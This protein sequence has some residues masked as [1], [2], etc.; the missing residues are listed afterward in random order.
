MPYLLTG[1]RYY[2]EEMAFWANYACCGPIN[3]DGVRSSQGILAI[4]EV[5]GFGWALRNI[6]DAAAYYPDASP[7]KAY[8]SQKVTN[9]LS[10]LDAYANSQDPITNP[11]PV[12]W[13]DK[14][15]EGPQYRALLGAELPGATRSIAPS[16]RG[17]RAAW[18]IA[19][20]SRSSSCGCSRA[21]RIIRAST[22]RPTSSPSA[23]R[24]SD[25]YAGVVPSD[26]ER[27]LERHAGPERPFAGFYGP[28][29]RLNLMIGIE[30]GW[31]GAQDAY[32]YLWPFVSSELAL[33]AGWAIGAPP[34]VGGGH[35]SDA[36]S[37][38]TIV[39][40]TT[41]AE[42]GITSTLPE[43]IPDFSGDLT[44]VT[45][46]S[47][48]SGNWSS[49][50]TWQGGQVPT[51]NQVVR[52]AQGHTVTIINTAAVAY[53][54][55]VDGKL[56]FCADVNTRLT[57]TNLEVMAGSDGMGTPGVLEVGTAASPIAA[58]VTAEIVIANSPLGGSVADP[59]QFGT[60]MIVFG[61]VVD[62]RQ[63][64]DADLRA[65]SRP[66]RSPARRR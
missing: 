50:S 25:R 5:H 29:A 61:K 62:A 11:F 52:I 21:S 20:R 64:E 9:N 3:G 12:L 15:Q 41:E 16:S 32:D 24:T 56:A 2:A 35:R 45:I 18:R 7:M 37:A 46:T 23:R 43:G 17:L 10:W 51:L 36:T 26:H 44:R 34:S 53:T 40:K 4:N 55:A 66:S 42:A 59:E 8:L 1:D 54:V 58:D 63:R 38:Q 27:D 57:V 47:A 13:V 30:S 22:A 28:E 39:S 65:R 33:R 48:Q 49:G 60:G 31:A 19:M 14:R 6:V